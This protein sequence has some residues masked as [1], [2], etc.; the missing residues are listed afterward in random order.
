MRMI[1]RVRLMLLVVFFL[2]FS[3]LSFGQI[4]ITVTFGPPAL[5]V[6]EQ[7]P[8]PDQGYIWTPGYWAWDPDAGQYYWV[9]GTWVLA[10]EPGYLWTPPWWGWGPGGYFF[11]AGFWGPRIGFYGGIN[12]GYGYFGNGYEGGR[13]EDGR[14]FY[15]RSVNNVNVTNIH[16][17][18]NTTI[19]NNNTTVNRVSY[20]GGNGGIAARP[21]PQEEAVDRERHIPPVAAQTQ[22]V[23]EA[24]SNP[25]LRAQVNHGKPP[26]AATPRPAVFTGRN[27]VHAKEAGAPYKP[28]AERQVPRPNEN[29]AGRPENN[30]PRPTHAS[31]LSQHQVPQPP[32]TGNPRLD[33]KYAQQQ[34]K[35]YNKMN[36]QHQ[37]LEQKQARQDQRLQQQHAS[38]AQRQQMEQRHAQQTQQMQARHQQQIQKLQQRQAP[39]QERQGPPRPK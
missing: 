25:Q 15:N 22:H 29:A 32:N 6:Y 28:P 2:G 38:E 9:P 18:Y 16:N 24:R 36:Q 13:W 8:C 12:Y 5:P 14:F 10:P 3:A 4:G 21:T 1:V 19:I 33:Q 17:T 26:I 27:V 7:P 34:Q 39:P 35:L 31:E 23:Q 11:H 20:N 30:V 37:Q